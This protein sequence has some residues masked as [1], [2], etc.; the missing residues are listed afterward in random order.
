MQ[1]EF[2]LERWRTGQI[3]FH[4]SSVDRSLRRHWPTLGVCT[5]SRVFAP[6]C[7]KS[8]D[9]LWL[10]DQGLE[11]L[12]VELAAAAVESF[13]LDNGLPARRR[14]GSPFDVYDAPGIR[15]LCGDLFAL[16]PALLGR[17]D[18]VYDRAALISWAPALRDGYVEHLV[19]LVSP[20]TAVL[21]I[22]L[23]YPQSQMAGPPFAV[24]GEEVARLYAPQF[25]VREIARE[26]ILPHEA[27]LRAKGLTE[28]FEVCYQLVRL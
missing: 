8:L 10:R 26:D 12:G 7:G 24:P 27:R 4:Q 13:F 5:G 19:K 28:L 18:A 15:L 14:A 17:V 9:L 21:L 11:V 25:E 1:P 6:L 2:W 23:E 3:A 20:G 22:T 16:T